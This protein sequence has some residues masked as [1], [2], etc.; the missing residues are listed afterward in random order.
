MTAVSE[1]TADGQLRG[2]LAQLAA[3]GQWAEL[4]PAATA[5]WG[6]VRGRVALPAGMDLARSCHDAILRCY[7]AAGASVNTTVLFFLATTM[8]HCGQAIAPSPAW[9]TMASSVADRL[10]RDGATAMGEQAQTVM[11]TLL[12]LWTLTDGR[13][14]AMRRW[15][16][17]AAM[18][19]IPADDAAVAAVS[20]LLHASGW[21]GRG[22]CPVAD[23]VGGVEIPGENQEV[24]V[25]RIQRAL[26]AL[27]FQ[28]DLPTAW[29]A[30]VFEGATLPWLELTLAHLQLDVAFYLESCNFTWVTRF[31]TEEHYNAVIP[32]WDAPMRAAGRRIAAHLPPLSPVPA[33]PRPLVGIFIHSASTLAHVVV[34][35]KDLKDGLA[36][37]ATSNRLRF[38]VY[39]FSGRDSR[40]EQMFAE[41]GIPVV[42]WAEEC[43]VDG[44]AMQ[45][46]ALRQRL[47][48]DRVAALLWLC[49]P[50]MLSFAFALGMAPRQIWLSVKFHPL[51]AEDADGFVTGAPYADGT[52]SFNG[53]P[54]KAVPQK[55]PDCDLSRA[56][57]GRQLRD[58]V[59]GGFDTVIGV[60]AREEK[61]R[62]PTY[63]AAVAEVLRTNPTACF[64]Y[65]GR[66]N[67]PELVGAFAEAGVE[68]QAFFVGWIDADVWI[69]VLDIYLDCW[70]LGSGLTA[71][72]AAAAAKPYVFLDTP[73][74]VMGTWIIHALDTAP[75]ATG[76]FIRTTFA[77]GSDREL[78]NR[79]ATPAEAIAAV[80]R[81]IGDPVL[82]QDSGR[83]YRRFY[84]GQRQLTAHGG[85]IL[86]D[87]LADIADPA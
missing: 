43:R 77:L 47:A 48:E 2:I 49:H 55:F 67:A 36:A 50:S 13:H 32:R 3:A 29:L 74:S 30:A 28:P 86:I 45:L 26:D 66:T 54:W 79:A 38:R 25:R 5:L 81:L 19:R 31:E 15:I 63:A 27:G 44:T 69:H 85:Q 72:H 82:R 35:H 58:Q 9:T 61:L 84:D 1:G 23:L 17:L 42:W 73:G 64:F 12:A 41:I 10:R 75:A 52:V 39:A 20:R 4:A 70:P 60:I 7:A 21:L 40:M 51:I 76:A 71:M 57:E 83:A 80:Q 65:T 22:D 68:S 8:D 59:F 87:Y 56:E 62:D 14:G 18:D 46:I 34:L 6:E 78:V 53:R 33:E 11:I 37:P 24:S 16:T